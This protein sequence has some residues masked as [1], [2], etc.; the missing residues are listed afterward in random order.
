[1]NTHAFASVLS[2]SVLIACS[3]DTQ[4]SSIPDHRDA[5]TG[6][7]N[8]GGGGQNGS[9][10]GRSGGASGSGAAAGTGGGLGVQCRSSAECPQLG[11]YMC[12]SVCQNG[13]CITYTGGGS[14]GGPGSGGTAGAGGGA[15]GGNDAGG[16]DA[17]HHR[18]D[19][20]GTGGAPSDAGPSDGG[21]YCIFESS[22]AGGAPPSTRCQ[23]F[24]AGCD[25]CACVTLPYSFCTCS[26]GPGGVL[27]RCLGV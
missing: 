1:M 18:H 23:P 12:S 11:C 16:I 5:S 13:R 6:G 9:G 20:A 7:Q 19:A 4:S 14:G 27:V 25:S 2:L 15:A 26:N 24:P 21:R 22:G 3:S 17:G 8:G 10:G